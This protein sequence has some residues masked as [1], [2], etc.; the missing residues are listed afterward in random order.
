VQFAGP[1]GIRR[2]V[3]SPEGD[4]VGKAE[5]T[6]EAL[7]AARD[8]LARNPGLASGRDTDDLIRTLAEFHDSVGHDRFRLL[9]GL[10]PP[11]TPL[12]QAGHLTEEQYRDVCRVEANRPVDERMLAVLYE[13]LEKRVVAYG[14]FIG[15]VAGQCRDIE[16]GVTA[17]W[18]AGVVESHLAAATVKLNLFGAE[19][20]TALSFLA[21]VRI[22]RGMGLAQVGE[23]S[24]ASA[25]LLALRRTD[26]AERLW[27]MV[28]GVGEG[29][30][31]PLTPAATFELIH[32]RQ[33]PDAGGVQALLHQEHAA[34]RLALRGRVPASSSPTG[35]VDTLVVNAARCEVRAET[36][37]VPPLPVP[38]PPAGGQSGSAN[39]TGPTK[40][41]QKSVAVKR[42]SELGIGIDE[43]ETLAFV[44]APAAGARVRKGDGKP[45]ALSGKRWRVV[46]EL[47]S[48]AS[49]GRRVS[50]RELERRLAEATGRGRS[51]SVEAAHAA[52]DHFRPAKMGKAFTDT[53]ADLRRSLRAEVDGPDEGLFVDL[54]QEIDL[55]F[56]V[57]GLLVDEDRNCTFGSAAD[58]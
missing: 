44:P 29:R 48:L 33:F 22:E 46:F 56:V 40:P 3:R 7:E 26:A 10:R 13:E 8:A 32:G 50:R 9:Y 55:G 27:G 2:P 54:G 11:R 12:E 19:I 39:G 36:L 20:T 31:D 5:P 34:V 28:L 25:A 37:V 42:W 49:D 57:R 4:A 47:A 15:E 41:T 45:L 17:S 35:E 24:D 58:S 18:K 30:A 21:E 23:V 38:P 52:A 6:P 14:R 1:L 43:S 51:G 53:L 16:N